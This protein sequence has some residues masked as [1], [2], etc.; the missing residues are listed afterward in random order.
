MRPWKLNMHKNGSPK[1]FPFSPKTFPFSPPFLLKFN[2]N[3]TSPDAA[4]LHESNAFS[5]LQGNNY[6]IE[7]KT[8]RMRKCLT[9]FS[10]TIKCGAAAW[11][12]KVQKCVK[13]A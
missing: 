7:I 6:K 5:F 3:R 8:A 11:I 10:R 1:T 4:I 12:P 2:R 9:K 13:D